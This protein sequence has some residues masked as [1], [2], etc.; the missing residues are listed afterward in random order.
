MRERW[1][2]GGVGLGSGGFEGP[3]VIFGDEAGITIE[4]GRI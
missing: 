3:S 2:C 1:A 4:A